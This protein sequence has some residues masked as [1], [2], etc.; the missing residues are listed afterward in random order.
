MRNL[1]KNKN[2]IFYFR[3]VI[4]SDLRQPSSSKEMM[5]SLGT[6][7]EFEATLKAS[8]L[9][10]LSNY[11]LNYC[12]QTGKKIMYKSTKRVND[13]ETFTL[14]F[15]ANVQIGDLKVSF[16]GT[17]EE[18]MN[19][20]RQFQPAP[21]SKEVSAIQNA[22]PEDSPYLFYFLDAYF[23]KLQRLN[24]S[25]NT[26]N[27]KK[28]ALREHK[29]YLGEQIRIKDLTSQ[30]L[31][32]YV[33]NL[34]LIPVRN[35]QT[36]SME[37]VLKLGLKPAN[38]HTS[39]GKFLVLKGYLDFLV[40]EDILDKN[41]LR[42]IVLPAKPKTMINNSYGGFDKEDLEQIFSEQLQMA[43]KKLPDRYWICILA[44]FTG[45]R[46]NELFQLN[47]S[48]VKCEKGIWFFDINIENNKHI[49][50]KFSIRKVPLHNE[51]IKLGFLQYIDA[52]KKN[53]INAIFE[54]T[55]TDP[56]N[57]Y[58]RLTAWFNV[59]LKSLKI[60]QDEYR[61]KVFHSFRHTFITELQRLNVP[62]EVRQ[63]I[64]GHSAKC[65]TID[66]YGE[67]SQLET[68]KEAIDKIDYGIDFPVLDETVIKLYVKRRK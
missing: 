32:K 20:V 25:Q 37:E 18:V 14:Q 3:K 40:E 23:K 27:N 50:N 64:A 21:V 51:I 13:F 39:E 48:D 2:G 33:K 6:K 53:K 7:D 47:I 63:S 61:R 56:L 11:L 24:I 68:M 8:P 46:V 42:E 22:V 30:F 1:F 49:K 28:R 62:L 10:N 4:P 35:D 45:C 59:Y 12:R 19:A 65:I 60:H 34:F 67:K 43:S 55:G 29:N 52:L 26:I 66:V 17:Q 15:L 44:L 57:G 54:C 31:K 38:Y 58:R 36:K 5:I 9:L 16:E 41:P